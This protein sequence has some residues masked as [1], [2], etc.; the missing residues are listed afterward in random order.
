MNGAD[1]AGPLLCAV[2][3]GT[4]RLVLNRPASG[5]ALSLP[6]IEALIAR[7]AALAADPAVHTLVIEGAGRHLCTGFDLSALEAETDASL[8]HRMVRIEQMLDMLW[9][10]P[11]QTHALGRGRITGAGA[12]LFAACDHRLI[13]PDASLQFPGVRFGLVL[14]TRRLGARVGAD[15]ALRILAGGE[16]VTAEAALAMGLATAPLDQPDQLGSAPP[17]PAPPVVARETFAALRRALD[18]GGADRDLAALVRSAA[19]PGLK[20]RIETYVA[21]LRAERQG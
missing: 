1:P 20:A 9:R 4:A 13:A 16:R 15:R 8:L 6:L 7:L 12:D 21:A 10:A 19:R 18:D 11:M 14:G 5:N 17:D 2:H 3:G